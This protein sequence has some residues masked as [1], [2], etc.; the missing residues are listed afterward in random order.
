VRV[1]LKKKVILIRFRERDLVRLDEL[2]KRVGLPSRS[3]LINLALQEFFKS[4]AQ[5]PFTPGAKR[6]AKIQMDPT[7]KRE[8]DEMARRLRTSRT[9]LLRMALKEFE[10]TLEEG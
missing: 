9:E 4:F 8:L 1:A 2:A 10:R 6:T 3:R 5:Q 7:I